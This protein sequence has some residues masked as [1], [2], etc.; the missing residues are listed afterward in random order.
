MSAITNAP[1][2]GLSI[3]SKTRKLDK[4][5]NNALAVAN[6]ATT[7]SAADEDEEVMTT[8]TMKMNHNNININNSG[9]SS[10]SGNADHVCRMNA[11]EAFQILTAPIGYDLP[12]YLQSKEM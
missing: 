7:V 6:D 9:D 3:P 12:A 5:A 10:S 8:M 1:S 4:H 11:N 2:G